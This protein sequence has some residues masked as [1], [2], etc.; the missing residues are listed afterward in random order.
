MNILADSLRCTNN[1]DM[2]ESHH[3]QVF[4]KLR[5]MKIS[6]CVRY[7]NHFTCHGASSNNTAWEVL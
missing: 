5:T 3:R 7:L 6:P 2:Y 4:T 1:E